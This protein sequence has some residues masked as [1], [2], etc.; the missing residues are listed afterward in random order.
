MAHNI[1][2]IGQSF[3]CYSA[4]SMFKSFLYMLIDEKFVKLLSYRFVRPSHPDVIEDIYDG[5]IYK[6]LHS[7]FDNPFNISLN[8]N[9]D[10]A[11]KFKSNNMQVWPVQFSINELP[12]LAR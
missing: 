1:F 6:E 11:P 2:K 8:L 9:Y 7:F 5:T 10:G 4:N 12:P 3:R